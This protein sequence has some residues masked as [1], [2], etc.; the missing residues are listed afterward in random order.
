M[1]NLTLLKELF[2]L[3]KKADKYLNSL[4]S[5]FCDAVIEND[6][7]QLIHRQIDLLKNSAFE[8]H[9][10]VVD[11]VL[12]EWSPR[13]CEVVIDD[14]TYVLDTEDKLWEHLEKVEGWEL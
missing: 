14:V 7:T 9:E 1:K 8:G 10:E 11:W 3:E 2:Y 6:Y 13:C 4:P 12:F 5:V